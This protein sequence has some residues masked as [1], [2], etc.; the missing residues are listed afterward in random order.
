MSEMTEGESFERFDE[1][2]KKAVSRA[3]ELG[4]ASGNEDWMAVAKN[5]E[6]FRTTGAKLHRAKALSRS[7]TLRMLDEQNDKAAAAQV[8]H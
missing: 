6:L 1:N 8:V 7:E 3:N 4:I 2:M 5:L